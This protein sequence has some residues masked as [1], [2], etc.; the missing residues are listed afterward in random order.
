MQIE[1]PSGTFLSLEECSYHTG[2][3]GNAPS[4]TVQF[5]CTSITGRNIQTRSGGSEPTATDDTKHRISAPKPD[6]TIGFIQGS[7][8]FRTLDLVT[9]NIMQTWASLPSFT[10]ETKG[11]Q[12]NCFLSYKTSTIVHTRY[13]ASALLAFESF[14]QVMMITTYIW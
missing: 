10:L 14:D 13:A 4:E 11:I 3:G 12:S 1:K 2:I 5:Y 9:P 7:M 8:V 6:I